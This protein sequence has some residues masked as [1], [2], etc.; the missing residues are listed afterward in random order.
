MTATKSTRSILIAGMDG[1]ETLVN[2]IPASAK[3]TFGPVQPGRNGYSS[4]NVLRIY[5]SQSNQLAVFR[6]VAS[7]RDLTLDVQVRE[8]IASE[9][10]E[11]ATGPDGRS[12]VHNSAVA[13]GVFIP[14]NPHPDAF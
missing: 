7:F 8:V 9:S 10:I 4:E 11:E 1:S 2:G 3:I 14:A 13:K 12:R 6:N 5:T